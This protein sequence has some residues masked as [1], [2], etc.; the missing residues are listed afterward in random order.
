[1]DVGETADPFSARFVWDRPGEVA[2]ADMRSAARYLAGEHDFASLCRHP[3]S[4]KST[5][6]RVHR[7]TISRV[8][9]RIEVRVK[10]NAFLHQMVRAIVGM[11]VAVGEGKIAPGEV[12]A[13]LA[14]RDRRGTGHLAPA[15]GLTLERVYY[16][17]RT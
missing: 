6:R 1:M 13:L 14:A 16:G 15:L 12:P 10:A 8:G 5:V 17:R 7:L 4:G 11:L 2:L 9:D 3:G